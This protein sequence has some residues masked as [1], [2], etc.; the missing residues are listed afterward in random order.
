MRMCTCVVLCLKYLCMYRS[1]CVAQVLEQHFSVHYGLASGL[2]TVGSSIS[3]AIYPILWQLLIDAGAEAS[4]HSGASGASM[5]ASTSALADE[6]TVEQIPNMSHAQMA[7]LLDAHSRSLS[8]TLF[9][10]SFHFFLLLFYC[11]RYSFSFTLT[12]LNWDTEFL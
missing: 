2:V 4:A 8:Y 11:F 5:N 1:C 7:A 3:Y 6:Y 12:V 10:V 9:F